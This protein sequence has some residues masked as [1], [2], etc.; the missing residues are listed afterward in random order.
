MKF[1]RIHLLPKFHGLAEEDPHKH[2]KEFHVVARDTRGLYQNEG[3]SIFLGWS[4]EGLTVFAASAFQHLG[5]Y[6]G[7]VSR[8]VLSGIK[9]C[10]HQKRNLWD[11][12]FY[13]GLTMMDIS[14]ID[15]ASGGALMDK[16]PVAT[17]HLISNMASNTQQFGIKGVVQPGCRIRNT[18]H[19]LSNSNNNKEFQLK[20]THLPA[21][22]E[23]HHPRPQD[24]NKTA[25]KHCEPFIV[26]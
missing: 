3:V 17:R 21:K 23:C 8:E 4:C 16:T 19:H 20:A 12:Y 13:E 22:H 2:L 5:R 18:K 9:N 24:A 26:G 14:M 10:N 25:S 6:D 11:K 15:A 1:G 7:H